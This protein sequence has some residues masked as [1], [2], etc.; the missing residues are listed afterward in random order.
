MAKFEVLILPI[1]KVENHPNAERLS[2]NHIRGYIAVSN[3]NEDGSHRYHE[4][5]LVAYVPL[6]AWVP[7]SV[8]KQRGYWDEAKNRGFLGGM[9]G[10][11]VMPIN[12]RRQ[13]SQGLIF[14]TEQTF[15][16]YGTHEEP[17]SYIKN[18][19]GHSRLVKAGDDVTNFLGIEKFELTYFGGQDVSECPYF[20]GTIPVEN[21]IFSHRYSIEDLKKY[22][23]LLENHQ[24]I[25]TELLHGIHCV[26]GYDRTLEVPFFVANAFAMLDPTKNNIY[27]QTAK[28]IW[29]EIRRYLVQ[30][31]AVEKLFIHGTIIGPGIQDITYG[32]EDTEFRASDII[33]GLMGGGRDSIPTGFLGVR[34]YELL[35][36][37][38]ISSAPILWGGKFD[39]NSIKVLASGPS[40]IGGGTRKGVVITSE[41]DNMIDGKRPI[42]K[43]VSEK[44]LLRSKGTEYK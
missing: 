11:V 12:L 30:M 23:T 13:L 9:Y 36:W 5:Q 14:P 2:L 35:K 3:K 10:N 39:L 37:L 20:E 40:S 16:D 29:T 18:G 27:T 21:N 31:P 19:Q 26:I 33:M 7:D 1:D 4:G 41:D 44:Y 32:L 42:L 28:P 17:H 6:N 34:K 22:P 15:S 8:L 24:V 38:N 25:V 43:E